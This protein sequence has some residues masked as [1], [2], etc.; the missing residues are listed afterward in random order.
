[1]RST[2]S[3]YLSRTVVSAVMSA[4]VTAMLPSRWSAASLLLEVLGKQVD[5]LLHDVDRRR[6]RIVRNCMAMH[7]PILS[8]Q[9]RQVNDASVDLDLVHRRDRDFVTLMTELAHRLVVHAAVLD[10]WQ[11]S[12]GLQQRRV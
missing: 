6:F 4:R 10:F 5:D 2:P 12:N 8:H 7:V 1:N 3:T 9:Q 11:S